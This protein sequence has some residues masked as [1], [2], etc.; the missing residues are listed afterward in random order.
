MQL[1]GYRL[2]LNNTTLIF[3]KIDDTI[4]GKERP[5]DQTS[6][7]QQARYYIDF[8]S[9]KGQKPDKIPLRKSVEALE[10]K[11]EKNEPLNRED[12]L[13]LGVIPAQ[14]LGQRQSLSNSDSGNFSRDFSRS[15]SLASLSSTLFSK[16][17]RE[18]QQKEETKAAL[19]TIDVSQTSCTANVLTEKMNRHVAGTRRIKKIYTNHYQHTIDVV[20]SETDS[21]L[22]CIPENRKK[23]A[24]SFRQCIRVSNVTQEERLLLESSKQQKTRLL[25]NR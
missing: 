3:I 5:F 25:I 16:E 23:T 13:S 17:N 22:Q 11:L 20:L 15:S 21:F 24:I 4:K 14:T 1:D 12:I 10:K 8:Y 6:V 18:S 19:P 7:W 9:C 2:E